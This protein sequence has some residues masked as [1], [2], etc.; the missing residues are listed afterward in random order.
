MFEISDLW[1]KQMGF[2]FE[3]CCIAWMQIQDTTL[4]HLFIPEHGFH[5][6]ALDKIYH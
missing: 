4:I 2:L 3:I 6:C 5:A 1:S